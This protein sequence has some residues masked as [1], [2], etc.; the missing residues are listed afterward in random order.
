MLIAV[1]HYISP[2]ALTQ[3]NQTMFLLL[4]IQPRLAVDN[5]ISAVH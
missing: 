3:E 4:S 5:K 2:N 1:V